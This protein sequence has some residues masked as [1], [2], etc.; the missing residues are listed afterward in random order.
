MPQH[1]FPLRLAIIFIF[2][3]KGLWHEKESIHARRAPGGDRHHR[4]ARGAAV[5]GGTSRPRSRASYAVLQRLEADWLGP[6]KLSRYVPEP[7]VWRAGTFREYLQFE[8]RRRQRRFAELGTKLVRRDS[9]VLRTETAVGPV[10]E[11][12]SH[13][14]AGYRHR[15]YD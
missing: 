1:V 2:L 3:G 11:R 12:D 9:A 8:P 14:L 6:A 5:A 13:Q 10:G 4:C 15:Q 7:S